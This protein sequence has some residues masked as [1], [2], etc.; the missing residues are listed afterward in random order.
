MIIDFR[1]ANGVTTEELAKIL[2]IPE[3]ILKKLQ[4]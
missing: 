4:D 3:K 1:I 2:N